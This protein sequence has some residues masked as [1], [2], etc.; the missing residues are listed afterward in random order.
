MCVYYRTARAVW[1]TLFGGEA[2]RVTHDVLNSVTARLN[3]ASVCVGDRDVCRKVWPEVFRDLDAD[4]R[5]AINI[6]H[7]AIGAGCG[8]D[9]PHL[10]IEDGDNGSG[11]ISGHAA[12][13]VHRRADGVLFCVALVQAGLQLGAE[14][15]NVERRI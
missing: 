6:D 7:I 1:H 10:P 3:R 13:L 14:C 15:L 2:D 9:M 8:V 11:G 5:H 4:Q 12:G